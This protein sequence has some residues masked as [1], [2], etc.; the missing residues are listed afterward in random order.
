MAATK[1]FIL[2]EN[3]SRKLNKLQQIRSCS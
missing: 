1:M 3:K 2:H